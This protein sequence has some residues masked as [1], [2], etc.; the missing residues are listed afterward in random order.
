MSSTDTLLHYI[1]KAVEAHNRISDKKITP[2]EAIKMYL[3]MT[4]AGR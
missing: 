1:L 4:K 3:E 2:L